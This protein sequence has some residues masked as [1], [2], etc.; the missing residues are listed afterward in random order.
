MKYKQ[1]FYS[2][3]L[4]IATLGSIIIKFSSAVFALLNAI[5]LAR[6][7]SLEDFGIYVLAL[8]TVSVI[9]IPVSLGL[10]EL[11]TR[12]ISKYEVEKNF[13]AMKGLLIRANQLLVISNLIAF[14]IAFIFQYRYFSGRIKA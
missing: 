11:L 4:R 14:A 13:P 9:M 8:T 12:Y 7:L 5:L 3:E 6:L 10:P 2:Q 1:L